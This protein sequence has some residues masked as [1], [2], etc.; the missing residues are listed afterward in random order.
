MAGSALPQRGVLSLATGRWPLSRAKLWRPVVGIKSG[1]A[2]RFLHRF[3]R[4]SSAWPHAKQA[5]SWVGKE[6]RRC[7]DSAQRHKK[8]DAGS[9]LPPT[10]RIQF[11]RGLCR[12]DGLAP[13]IQPPQP[14]GEDLAEANQ[15]QAEQQMDD[16]DQLDDHARRARHQRFL[17][18]AEADDH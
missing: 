3:F 17:G 7:P 9:A 12:Y 18:H 15:R 4:H 2:A 11:V 5:E 6:K 16:T 8:R 10:S 1:N 14:R 13:L